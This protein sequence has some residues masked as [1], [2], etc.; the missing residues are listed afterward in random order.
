[1]NY[2][3]IAIEAYKSNNVT[4]D[5]FA[6]W[7]HDYARGKFSMLEKDRE[8][9]FSMHFAFAEFDAAPDRSS[10]EDEFR[11]ALVRLDAA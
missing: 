5:Q 3:Q 9:C 10:A 6:D 8:T 11:A 4:L 1:M 2:L 7:F